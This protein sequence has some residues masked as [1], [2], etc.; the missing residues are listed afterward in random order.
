MELA[1]N[2]SE[3]TQSWKDAAKD[4]RCLDPQSLLKPALQ[5]WVDGCGANPSLPTTFGTLMGRLW[6]QEAEDER[7]WF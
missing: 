5:L 1:C 4:L 7:V 6:D 2:T 3:A